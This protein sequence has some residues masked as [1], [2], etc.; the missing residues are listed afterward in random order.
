MRRQAAYRLA[1]D[2]TIERDQLQKSDNIIKGKIYLGSVQFTP[3][4]MH[5]IFSW[6]HM[7]LASG[8]RA[9]HARTLQGVIGWPL[10]LHSRYPLH[11]L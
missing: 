2:Q 7:S 10:H 8:V 6:T 3:T 11:M 5:S 1:W 9:M 4:E